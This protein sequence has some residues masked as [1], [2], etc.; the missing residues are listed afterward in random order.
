MRDGQTK[1]KVGKSDN[2]TILSVITK[3]VVDNE[4]YIPCTENKL[5]KPLS[6]PLLISS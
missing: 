6:P 3:S 4:K 2:K 1:A 5:I